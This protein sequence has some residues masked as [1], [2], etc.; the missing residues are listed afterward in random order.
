[1]KLFNKDE[2]IK[3]L[4]SIYNENPKITYSKLKEKKSLYGKEIESFIRLNFRSST[5]FSSFAYENE[6]YLV[7][8]HFFKIN[9]IAESFI[10]IKSVLNDRFNVYYDPIKFIFL[11]YDHNKK[12]GFLRYKKFKEDEKY[13]FSTRRYVKYGTTSTFY[14]YGYELNEKINNVNYSFSRKRGSQ[15]IVNSIKTLEK[16][17]PN[18]SLPSF[19]SLRFH[20]NISV[21]SAHSFFERNGGL[22]FFI[23]K[24]NENNFSFENRF[25][26]NDKEQIMRSEYEFY[27]WSI[28]H[29]NNIPYV[30]EPKNIKG[31]LP[32]FYLSEK[33]IY[34]ELYGL[35]GKKN[36]DAKTK[37]KIKKYNELGLVSCGIYPDNNDPFESIFKQFKIL[38]GEEITKPCFFTYCE[39]FMLNYG[40][41]IEKVKVICTEIDDGII[42]PNEVGYKYGYTFNNFVLSK[43]G[44]WRFCIIK[45]LDKFPKR[46]SLVNNHY[47][48]EDRII[49]ELKLCKKING[50]IPR[51]ITCENEFNNGNVSYGIILYLCRKYGLEVFCKGGKYHGWIPYYIDKKPTF[52]N[53]KT[54]F[55]NE[56]I[57]KINYLFESGGSISSIS[58]E[59]GV[60]SKV[61]KRV[62]KK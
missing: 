48:T 15:N 27:L 51:K 3:K 47:Y 8:R 26:I 7:G 4:K 42:T 14:V 62:L 44:S 35:S 59:M 31:L 50:E 28:L 33:D 41:F 60:T 13:L 23:E 12:E 16:H 46:A 45:I 20:N 36:Y 40:D 18:K 30:Y 1:M 17:F 19:S 53:K 43:Y 11:I 57:K 39:N 24:V 10:F 56:E 34:L 49:E 25:Y 61:I 58:K 55:S 54:Q 52:I 5:E 29:K 2:I 9:L 38:Y 6:I 37:K 22:P 32:D 21:R